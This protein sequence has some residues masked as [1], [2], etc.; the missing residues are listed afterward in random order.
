[1]FDDEI[2]GGRKGLNQYIFLHISFYLLLL[3]FIVSEL[4]LVASSRI[5]IAGFF[6]RALAIA[7][8]NKY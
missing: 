1:M 8:L 4:Y 3:L 2:T 7:I 6:S 5:R